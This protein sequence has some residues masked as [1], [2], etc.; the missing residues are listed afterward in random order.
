[1]IAFL[2]GCGI[3]ILIVRFLVRCWDLLG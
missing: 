1:M 2:I 3:G